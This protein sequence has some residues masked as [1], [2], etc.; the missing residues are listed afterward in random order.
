MLFRSAATEVNWPRWIESASF[1]SG[2]TAGLMRKDAR[3]ALQLAADV[4]AGL[5]ACAA[6]V[7]AWTD[8]PVADSADFNRVPAVLAALPADTLAASPTDSLPG[9]RDA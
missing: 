5:D 7:R 8:S 4:G 2:F 1:D 6:A 3:L 9:A